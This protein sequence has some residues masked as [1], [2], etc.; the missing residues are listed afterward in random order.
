[1]MK[2]VMIYCL[3]LLIGATALTS[4]SKDEDDQATPNE[5]PFFSVKMDGEAFL[6]EG[7]LAYGV[8]WGDHV[9]IYGLKN[10]EGEESIYIAIPKDIL[11]TTYTFDDNT[12]GTFAVIAWE[13]YTY[14][15]FYEG[16]EGQVTI[17]SFDGVN[18][19]GT[20]SFTAVD[21]EDPNRTLVATE[22]EFDVDIR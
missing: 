5:G 18:I 13:D 7:F 9:N 6:A 2:N 20:F 16:G 4:C 12:G 15:T 21:Y 14:N 1:M 8:N 19:K 17:T 22:G 3:A 11:E 10:L